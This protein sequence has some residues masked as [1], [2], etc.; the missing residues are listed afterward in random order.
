M[1][2][3]LKCCRDGIEVEHYI[4]STNSQADS[5]D[6]SDFRGFVDNM[7]TRLWGLVRK[8]TCLWWNSRITIVIR[9]P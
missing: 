3:G 7:Y 1:A 5:E 8:N 4:P 9:P 6:H 2:K